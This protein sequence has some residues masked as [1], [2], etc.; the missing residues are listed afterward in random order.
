MRAAGLT[1]GHIAAGRHRGHLFVKGRNV[2]V[3]PEAEMVDALVPSHADPCPYCA[4]GGNAGH[5]SNGYFLTLEPCSAST[6]GGGAD[7]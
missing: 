3:V 2:A 1:N 4:I 6:S 7:A 5:G